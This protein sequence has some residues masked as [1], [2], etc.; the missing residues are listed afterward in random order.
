MPVVIQNP[1]ALAWGN[2]TTMNNNISVNLSKMPSEKC[3]NCG[4]TIF[5]K[6]TIIKK[7]P[8]FLAGS[9]EDVIAEIAYN[10]CDK[11]KMPFD[12]DE[13]TMTI[14]KDAITQGKREEKIDVTPPPS[15]SASS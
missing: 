6:R 11:C 5:S 13:K 14:I 12:A 2:S 4:W 3:S 10:S 8:R 9:Q 15:P 7:I 1:L